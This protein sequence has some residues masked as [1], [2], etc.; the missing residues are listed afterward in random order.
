MVDDEN[1]LSFCE[2]HNKAG[3]VFGAHLDVFNVGSYFAG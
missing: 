3:E 2:L 1:V